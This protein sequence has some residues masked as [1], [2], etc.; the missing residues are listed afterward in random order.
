[1]AEN[2]KKLE[3]KIYAFQSGLKQS[4][5]QILGILIGATGMG[6]AF[7]ASMLEEVDG[8]LGLADKI[9]N[10]YFWI[11]W[12]IIFI[13]VIFVATL[14][15]RVAKNDAKEKESF[16]KV[17]SDYQIAKNKAR[18]N[19]KYLPK[20]TQRKNKDI[21]LIKQQEI[22]EAADLDWD[23]YR[24]GYYLLEKPIKKRVWY[25]FFKPIYD[26]NNFDEKRLIKDYQKKRLKL[27]KKIKIKKIYSQDLT[28]ESNFS[29]KMTYSHLPPDE[30]SAEKSFVRGKMITRAFT[31][32]AFLLVGGLT[33]SWAGWVSALINAFG[34]LVAWGGA[35]IQ[36]NDYVNNVL[37]LRYVG[38]R[39]LLDEFND[40]VDDFKEAPIVIEETKPIEEDNII[41]NNSSIIEKHFGGIDK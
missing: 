36:G 10:A 22:V 37:T 25:K 19:F 15:Y 16:K 24:Q 32:F 13:I 8:E 30:E 23:L 31:T 38:Q 29:T 28:Q 12:G 18:P 5:S 33:F 1:M 2:N 3:T 41:F 40:N 11:M 20:F 6:V 35:I 34:V 17:V 14:T 26:E 39:D 9:G 27:L 21:L 4:L 7:F